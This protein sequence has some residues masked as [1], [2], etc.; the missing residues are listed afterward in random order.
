MFGDGIHK[1]D[2]TRPS[3]DTA[4]VPDLLSPIRAT[5]RMQS[6]RANQHLPHCKPHLHQ[7]PQRCCKRMAAAASPGVAS[8]S[9]R[10]ASLPMKRAPSGWRGRPSGCCGL[11]T[12]GPRVAVGL[13]AAFH[14]TRS[15][16]EL[17]SGRKCKSH[18][19]SCV[20]EVLAAAHR[21]AGRLLLPCL[22]AV[23]RLPLL[24]CLLAVL[25]AEHSA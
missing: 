20:L 3:L 18:T 2:G 5:Q 1:S 7:R 17:S 12:A 24:H 19:A 23:R 10:A 14:Y 22:L 9:E 15:D 11:C 8:H 21:A 6:W 13:Y 4:T 16:F 25:A